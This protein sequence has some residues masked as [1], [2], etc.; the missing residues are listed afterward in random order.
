MKNMVQVKFTIDSD[1]V[2]AF[3]KRCLSEGVSMTFVITQWMKTRQ[4]VKDV[5]TNLSTRPNRRK[6]LP[7]VIEIL[8]SFLYNEEDYRDSIPEAFLA[9]Y[10]T[11]DNTCEKLLEAIESLEEAY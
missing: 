6:A 5:K 10:E 3:K 2:S 9:R 7:G 4:P 11:A 1:V 8:Q